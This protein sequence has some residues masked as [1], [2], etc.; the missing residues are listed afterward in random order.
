MASI[1]AAMEYEAMCKEDKQ[2]GENGHAEYKWTSSSTTLEN[3]QE[4]IIQFQFQLVRNA[5]I[6]TMEAQLNTILGYL[7]NHATKD[8]DAQEKKI[9]LIILYKLIGQT[10]NIH[11]GRGEYTLAYMQILVWN[12]YFPELAKFA[13]ETFVKDMN[14]EHKAFGSWKD[15]KY[16]CL[17]VKSKGFSPDHPLIQH[18]IQL[19]N[20]QIK[21]DETIVDQV[22]SMEKSTISLAGKWVARESSN[23]FGWLNTKLAEHYFQHY[24]QTAKTSELQKRASNK[25]QMHFRKLI[26]KLN[27]YLDTI[28]IKQ[29][30]KKWSEIDH[31]KTTSITLKNQTNAL[32]NKTK[33][34]KE[35]STD[36]DRITCSENFKAY[37]ESRMKDGKELKGSKIGLEQFTVKALELL[38]RNDSSESLQ[39]EKDM[40]NSQWRDNSNSNNSQSLGPML[41]MVDNSGSM[42]GNPQNAAIALGARIAEKSSLGK[43]AI[44]FASVPEFISLE[45]CTDFISIV[46]AFVNSPVGYS[47]NFYA[48]LDLIL[49]TIERKQIPAEEVDKMVL[50]LL[51]DMQIDECISIEQNNTGIEPWSTLYERIKEKYAEVGKRMYGSPFQVPHI[52]FWNLRQTDGFPTLS[53]QDNTTMMSGYSPALLNEF[54]DMGIDALKE[55][56]PWKMF[57]KTLDKAEYQ[58]LED[59]MK[60]D[61]YTDESITKYN[62]ITNQIKI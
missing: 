26:T 60:T 12:N 18:S 28:Q 9:L 57:V 41:V 32:L 15:I 23:K 52:L 13:I 3:I 24:M 55:Y 10:R 30:A 21:V 59:R 40:L 36:P 49:N 58:C 46:Q 47:T 33:E 2:L 56:T 50:V 51:S 54:C 20:E 22:A 61:L 35:R 44:S 5:D 7:T 31:S 14:K 45:A 29:C 4:L 8:Q 25:C 62:N 1:I 37:F 53:K 17:Y 19:I 11:N 38:H 39:L 6:Q 48:A 42:S 16:L 43:C 27:K 34:N